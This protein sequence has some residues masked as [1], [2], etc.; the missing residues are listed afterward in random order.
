MP[1]TAPHRSS[2]SRRD[3]L[4][5]MAGAGGAAFAPGAALAQR[6]RRPQTKT[7]QPKL[8]VLGKFSQAN[9][10]FAKREGFTSIGLWANP[11]TALDMNQATPA[12]IAKVK[13]AVQASG[14]Y[15]S[16]VATV[17]NHT[18]ADPARRKQQIAYFVKVLELGAE[19]GTPYVATVSGF[20]AGQPFQKQVDEVVR[21]YEENYFPLCE[22]HN[23]KILWEPWPGPAA[24]PVNLATGPVGFEALFKAF[25]DS[26]Y[27]GLQYDPSHL[28]RQMMDP[29]QCARDFVSKIYDVHLKDTE[30]LWHVLR[31]VGINPPNGA[32]WWR[33]RL[34]GLGSIDWAAF[35][36]VLMEGGYGGAMNIEHEDRFY[37]FPYPGDDFSEAYCEGF[38]MAHRFLR[39]YVPD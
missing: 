6:G 8:G 16:N 38:R 36:T 4:A 7:W 2:V 10:D 20:L 34:P 21:V 28:V 9:L 37:G 12:D 22:K 29:I 5:A 39:Q 11:R 18:D 14:L 23:L 19:L 26:P 25:R 32:T 31:R 33:Y 15:L 30:I 24:R 35:F 1:Q 13:A 17:V 27:V 3:L